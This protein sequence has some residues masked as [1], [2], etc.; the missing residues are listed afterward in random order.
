MLQQELADQPLLAVGGLLFLEHL[1]DVA[2][3]DHGVHDFQPVDVF[4]RV[5]LAVGADH[6]LELF[7]GRFGHHPIK[8][9]E[10]LTKS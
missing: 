9:N 2:E 7:G 10:T 4:E 5:E 8:G 6:R 1:V 3:V